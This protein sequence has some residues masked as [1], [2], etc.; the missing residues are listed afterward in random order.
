[1]TRAVLVQISDC[2]VVAGPEGEPAAA[3]LREVV[4]AVAALPIA[5]E[6]VLV[7][8]D[9]VHEGGPDDY[10]FARDLL[11][12]LP[13]PVYAI[14]GNHDD[15]ALV[16]ETFGDPGEVSLGGLRIVLCDTVV[17]GLVAGRLDVAALADRLAGDDRPTIVAM[18]HPP[19]L[20]GIAA[21]DAIVL[22]AE[23]REG[24]E[25]LLARSPQ[26]VRVICGH[27]HRVTFETLGGCGVFTGPA[28]WQQIEPG[29]EPGAL[30]FVDRG[31]AFAIHTWLNGALVTQL[32]PV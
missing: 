12:P 3:A 26:V 19:L 32:Q 6:A 5:P 17:P 7:S 2:H 31:R 9:V 29:D 24:L 10:A 22:P 23:D 11:A 25:A 1:V 4:A 27:V 14:P 30:S 8:G 20:T 15:P 13:A 28:S 18:H 16:R 21:L